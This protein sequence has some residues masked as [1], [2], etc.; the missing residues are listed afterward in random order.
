MQKISEILLSNG[1][2]LDIKSTEKIEAIN[3]IR[4]A[5]HNISPQKDHPIDLVLWVPNR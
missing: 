4:L 3:A 1:M 5:L 2:V